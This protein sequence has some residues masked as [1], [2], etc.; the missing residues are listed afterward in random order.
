ML[1]FLR[2]HQEEQDATITENMVEYLTELLQDACDYSWESAKGAHSVLLH[3]MQD[4]VV[5]WSN[6]KEVNKIQKRYAQT[7]SAHQGV[8][9]ERSEIT[10]VVPC[11]KYNKGSCPH[12]TDH[13]WQNM[14]LKLSCQ[15]CFSTFNRHEMHTKKECTKA[16]WFHCK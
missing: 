14:L 2:I 7:S 10:K 16:P 9:G 4:G 6:L 3:R 11:F 12:N 13:E 5:N 15:Y 8:V 1:G